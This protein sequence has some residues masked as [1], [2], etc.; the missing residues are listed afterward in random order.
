ME[1]HL[2]VFVLN[3]YENLSLFKDL[4]ADLGISDEEQR[5]KLLT[6]AGLMF[7]KEVSRYKERDKDDDEHRSDINAD[8]NRDE[9]S[10]KI[11]VNKEKMKLKRIQSIIR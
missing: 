3:G 11:S 5:E 10:C 2:P 1:E 9:N 8:S 7:P 6:I 4:D